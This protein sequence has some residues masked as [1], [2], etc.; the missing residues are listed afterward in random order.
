MTEAEPSQELT[1]WNTADYGS[2]CQTRS[3]SRIND[4][5]FNEASGTVLN[6]M[7]KLL[8]LMRADSL[9]FLMKFK[10]REIHYSTL[11]CCHRPHSAESLFARL[12]ADIP[13]HKQM[14]LLQASLLQE[15]LQLSKPKDTFNYNFTTSSKDTFKRSYGWYSFWGIH[16]QNGIDACC[17]PQ[18]FHLQ[19]DT[20]LC[21]LPAAYPGMVPGG[22]VGEG[23]MQPPSFLNSIG[24]AD[25]A[26]SALV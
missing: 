14:F 13:W 22:D 1:F 24:Q 2:K 8:A 26:A 10:Y 18:L 21:R 16:L 11:S 23:Q 17:S 7:P 9:A 3:I 5:M 25:R 6:F 12:A 15:G 20:R 19:I 4:P